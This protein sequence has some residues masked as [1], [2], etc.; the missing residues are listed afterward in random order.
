MSKLRII[1]SLADLSEDIAGEVP[2]DLIKNWL[3]SDQSEATHNNIL[4]QYRVTGT[5][6][7][8]D[9]S[10]LSKLS[11]LKPLVEV[12][13]I[14]NAPK[15]IIAAHGVPI[16]GEP[17]GIWVAD[18]TQMFYPDSVHP[19][20]IVHQM[21]A[22]MHEIN[23]GPLHIGL[24]MHYGEFYK[25]G[26]GLFG[27]EADFVEE[28]AENQ[29]KGGEIIISNSVRDH[30]CDPL[31]EKRCG[32]RELEGLEAFAHSFDYTD[33]VPQNPKRA[34]NVKYP[35][36]FSKE[37]LHLLKNASVDQLDEID[38]KY[39][40]VKTIILIKFFH[41]PDALLL[42]SL[43]YR[44]AANQMLKKFDE[45]SSVKQVKSN[46]D[47][48][49]FTCDSN[50][51][52]LAFARHIID[53]GKRAGFSL[54]VAMTRGDVLLFDLENNKH[55]IAGSPV[56]IASKLAEDTTERGKIF[57][58]ASVTAKISEVGAPFS[59]VAGGVEINGVILS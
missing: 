29:T 51:D 6:V 9:S 53:E 20:E 46:G 27:P 36:P 39:E 32:R 59:I 49:I 25:I 1:P 34:E 30:L 35:A 8:S 24:A 16:G 45:L 17:T 37:F 13:R 3:E 19:R 2:P 54:N 5:V 28:V 26:E 56:N 7:S 41:T 40:A 11:K 33:L 23:C 4:S 10:G 38:D 43:S 48:G 47:L 18:N 31:L 44:V 14:V 42:N 58:E 12:L 50:D 21:V 55:D 57:V 52:A 22:A 15:E